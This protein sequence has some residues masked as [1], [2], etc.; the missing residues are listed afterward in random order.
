M[1]R[2]LPTIFLCALA[3]GTAQGS[4][5]ESL[6]TVAAALPPREVEILLSVG[7]EYGLQG[8]ALKL[9]LVIRKIENGAAGIEMGVASNYPEHRARRYAGDL[10]KSLRVQAKWAAGTIKKHYTGDLDAFARR[11][12]PPKWKHWSG[13]AKSWMERE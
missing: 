10:D 2:V 8:R 5:P 9:M 12:C 6:R 7:Q 3:W 13:M 1:P 11:Y 4:V